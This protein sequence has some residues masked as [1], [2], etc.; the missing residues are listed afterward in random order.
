MSKNWR[1][2]VAPCVQCGELVSAQEIAAEKCNSC[3]ERPTGHDP[4]S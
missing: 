3:G 4:D 2:K 1:R